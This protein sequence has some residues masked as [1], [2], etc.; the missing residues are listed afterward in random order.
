MLHKIF[1]YGSLKSGH[2]NNTILGASKLLGVAQT[3]LSWDMYDCGFPYVI[4]PEEEGH[5][6]YGEVYEVDDSTLSRLDS[7]EGHPTHYIR[8]HSDVM[9]NNLVVPIQMYVG[10]DEERISKLK[11]IHPNSNGLLIWK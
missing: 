6:V 11:Q 9:L 10:V 3:I 8:T 1:T 4:S 5:T 7:L 2:W